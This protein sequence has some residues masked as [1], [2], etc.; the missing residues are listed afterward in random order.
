ML[1]ALSQ[2][3]CRIAYQSV[4]PVYGMRANPSIREQLSGRATGLA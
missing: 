4:T 3:L 2:Q 1:V